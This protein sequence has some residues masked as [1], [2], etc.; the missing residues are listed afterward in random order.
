VSARDG[1]ADG[2]KWGAGAAQVG[3]ILWVFIMEILVFGGFYGDF[4]EIFGVFW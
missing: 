3:E 1:D 4:Y 2:Q